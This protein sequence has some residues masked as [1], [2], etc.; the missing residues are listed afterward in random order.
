[1]CLT[2]QILWHLLC[3]VSC[4]HVYI[5]VYCSVK[6]VHLCSVLMDFCMLRKTVK[7]CCMANCCAVVVIR[8]LSCGVF[9]GQ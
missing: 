8:Q 2:K 7:L 3:V 9:M 1:M 5:V 4:F 6:F